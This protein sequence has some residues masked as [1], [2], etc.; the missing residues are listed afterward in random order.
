MRKMRQLVLLFS[1]LVTTV[2]AADQE[3]R[4]TY[5][6]EP[7]YPELAAKMNLHGVVKMKIWIAPEGNVRRL[8]YIGGHPVLAEAVL[9]SVKSW[10]YVPANS[11]TTALLE[12]K[13]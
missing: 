11:E 13:F 9:K 2:N 8:E 10:K 5:R 7:A 3:R 4:I 1:L 6:E 12:F